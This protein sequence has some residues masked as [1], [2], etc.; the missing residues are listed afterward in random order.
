MKIIFEIEKMFVF[1]I[2]IQNKFY[3]WIHNI[4][5]NANSRTITSFWQYCFYV[6][7]FISSFYVLGRFLGRFFYT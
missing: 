2:S 1:S 5:L 6:L 7:I 3:Q 4:L